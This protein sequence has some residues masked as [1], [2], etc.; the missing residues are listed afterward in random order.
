MKKFVL[1]LTLLCMSVLLFAQQTI[2]ADDYFQKEEKQDDQKIQTLMN[3]FEVKRISGFGGPTMSFTTIKDEF[4]FMMGGGGGLIINNLYLGGYGEDLSTS[5]YSGIDNPVRNLE[6]GHGGFWLGYEIA[7]QRIIHP[8]VS[9]RIGWGQIVGTDVNSKRI[10]DNIF[11]LVPTVSAEINFTRF[12]KVNVGA[13][14]RQTF[15]VNTIPGFTNNDFSNVGV[16]MSFV[17]GWF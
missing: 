14:Y 16:F 11:V 17:F 6:F 13:E 15:N 4:A 3:S 2:T 12:F 10:S 8:V 7:H 9:T 1:S 5:L